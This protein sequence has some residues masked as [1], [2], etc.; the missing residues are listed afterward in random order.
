MRDLDP[1]VALCW[2]LDN[3]ATTTLLEDDISAVEGCLEGYYPLS[4]VVLERRPFLLFRLVDKNGDYLQS[5]S[6]FVM[7]DRID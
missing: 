2:N 1:A 7:S 6:A 3:A 5:N 4:L